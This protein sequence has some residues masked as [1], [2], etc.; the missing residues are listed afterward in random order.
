MAENYDHI[1]KEHINSIK[2]SQLES[3]LRPSKVSTASEANNIQPE[4][5]GPCLCFSSRQLDTGAS[6][7][8]ILGEKIGIPR[9]VFTTWFPNLPGIGTIVVW[10]INQ[11]QILLSLQQH[12][13]IDCLLFFSNILDSNISW[14][15][16]FQLRFYRFSTIGWIKFSRRSRR[17]IRAINIA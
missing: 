5:K 11:S 2:T 12:L 9:A 16:S 17:F 7:L 13:S 3:D 15:G 14:N 1:N 6:I 4:S 10:I 8:S